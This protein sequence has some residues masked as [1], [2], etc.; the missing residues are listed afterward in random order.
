MS[1]NETQMGLL[2]KLLETAAGLLQPHLKLDVDTYQIE[3]T[4]KDEMHDVAREAAEDALRDR[5]DDLFCDGMSDNNV[6]T[7]DTIGDYVKDED[8]IDEI[9][10]AKILRVLEHDVSIRLEVD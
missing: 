1:I 8:D 9:V 3:E 5:F 7:E 10:S 2:N 6:I 4:V